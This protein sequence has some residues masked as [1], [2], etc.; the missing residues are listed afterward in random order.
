MENGLKVIEIGVGYGVVKNTVTHSWDN[1]V[2]THSLGN[3]TDISV[4]PS[5]NIEYHFDRIRLFCSYSYEML[6]EIDRGRFNMPNIDVDWYTIL[7][8]YYF[9][10]DLKLGI[11]FRF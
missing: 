9:V 1:S 11:A 2:H 3:G 10:G 5:V 4:I 6:F 8:D 7:G